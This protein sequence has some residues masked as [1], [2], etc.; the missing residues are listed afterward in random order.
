MDYLYLVVKFF[1]AGAIIVGV[2]LIVQQV[3]PRYGGILAAAPITTTIA[4]V[5]TYSEAGQTLTRDLVLGSFLFA[6]P[7]LIFVLTLY[8][9]MNRFSFISSLGGAFLIWIGGVVLIQHLLQIFKM[10]T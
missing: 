9:L 6:I 4:F 5:V 2:T 7:T 8:L 3:D 10:V 1:I